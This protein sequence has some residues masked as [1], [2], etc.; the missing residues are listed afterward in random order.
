[1]EVSRI[2]NNI[3]QKNFYYEFGSVTWN[4]TIHAATGVVGGSMFSNT[5]NFTL[6][7]HST[8]QA[9]APTPEFG[10]HN[11]S[12]LKMCRKVAESHYPGMQ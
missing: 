9:Q 11:E 2:E 12:F 1:M 5:R 8:A 7:F 6:H 10:R 3:P 4:A